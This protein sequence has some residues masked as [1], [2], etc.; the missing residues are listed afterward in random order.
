MRSNALLLS[1]ALCLTAC[2]SA[3]TVRVMETCPIPPALEL[4][5]PPGALEQSFIERMHSFLQGRLL[6]PTSYELPSSNAKLP[7]IK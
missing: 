5:L 6:E 2:A 4:D 1:I 7:T 3:P